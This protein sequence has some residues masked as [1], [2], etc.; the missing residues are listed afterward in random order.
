MSAS[1]VW[2]PVVEKIR[3]NI[4]CS[5]SKKY[6]SRR[7]VIEVSRMYFIRS[8][9]YLSQNRK[10]GSQNIVIEMYFCHVKRLDPEMVLCKDASYNV[11]SLI[12]AYQTKNAINIF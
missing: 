2:R 4:F 9:K 3:V 8:R 1:K 6:H 10:Y 11:M 5:K 7:I 12:C